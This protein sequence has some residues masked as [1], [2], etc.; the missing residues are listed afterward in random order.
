M[1]FVFF[2]SI[3]YDI[4]AS[5]MTFFRDIL[6]DNLLFRRIF[7]LV[8]FGHFFDKLFLNKG[9]GSLGLLNFRKFVC[10]AIKCDIFGRKITKKI[11]I[12][13]YRRYLMLGIRYLILFDL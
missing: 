9:G 6:L 13:Q 2:S 7:L 4:V 8:F 11:T 10:L 3:Q 1:I 12:F 5:E